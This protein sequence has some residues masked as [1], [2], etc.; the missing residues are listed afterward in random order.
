M[1]MVGCLVK[2]AGMS[3]IAQGIP[4]VFDT[5]WTHNLLQIDLKPLPLLIV[6]KRITC[7]GIGNLFM[8][9]YLMGVYMGAFFLGPGR[10]NR[11]KLIF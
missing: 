8:H 9:I 5:I 7:E 1:I 2:T 10:I 11:K 3:E 6:S 4:P